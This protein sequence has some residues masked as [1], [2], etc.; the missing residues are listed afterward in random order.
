MSV[1]WEEAFS[2]IQAAVKPLEGR[3]IKAIAGDQADTESIIALKVRSSCG[4]PRSPRAYCDVRLA[5]H[6]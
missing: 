5:G 6:A 2:A 1:T 3:H 4:L